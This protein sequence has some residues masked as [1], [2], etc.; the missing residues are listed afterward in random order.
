LLRANPSPDEGDLERDAVEKGD[1][2]EANASKPL[3]FVPVGEVDNA[4]GDL[5]PL[6]GKKA[7]EEANTD[8]EPALLDDTIA[9]GEEV[10][11]PKAD[12]KL[13][14]APLLVPARGVGDGVDF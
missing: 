2:A 8:E 10:F 4:F 1:D 13:D 7:D 12:E 14:A 5:L 3:R 6:F 11:M 9:N